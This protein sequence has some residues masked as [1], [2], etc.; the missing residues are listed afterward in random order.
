MLSITQLLRNLAKYM[1]KRMWK[2]KT[3]P[4]DACYIVEQAIRTRLSLPLLSE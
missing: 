2:E 1:E 4:A 3:Y